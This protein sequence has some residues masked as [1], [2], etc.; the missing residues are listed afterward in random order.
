VQ[1][2][3]T[4]EEQELVRRFARGIV[5]R[6][7]AMPATLFLESVRPLHFVGG[8][9]LHFLSPMAGLIVPRWELDQ[10][11]TLLENREAVP[12]LVEVIERL[13]NEREAA[14]RAAKR[15]RR[16]AGQVPQRR[17]WRFWRR[18]ATRAPEPG[19]PP[20]EPPGPVSR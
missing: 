1:P 7:M 4:P 19:T 2:D 9:F 8:N 20:P 3:W 15:A 11:G 5:D 10:L 16:A 14:A 17:R 18:G 13:E 12:Y 6:G